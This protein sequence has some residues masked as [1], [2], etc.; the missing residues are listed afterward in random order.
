MSV[1]FVLA[2]LPPM[3]SQQVQKQYHELK[4]V[5]MGPK[6]CPHVTSSHAQECLSATVDCLPALKHLVP[7]QWQVIFV[8]RRMGDDLQTCQM[9]Q[10]IH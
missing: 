2:F 10:R 3:S 1:Q 6:R 4:E 7:L 8:G 5:N 9:V